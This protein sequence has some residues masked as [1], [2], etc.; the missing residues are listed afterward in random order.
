MTPLTDKW[1]EEHCLVLDNRISRD[2][3]AAWVAIQADARH[4]RAEAKRLGGMV[5]GEQA[6]RKAFV[7]PFFDR[8]LKAEAEVERL[9][10]RLSWALGMI[11]RL[12]LQGGDGDVFA[13]PPTEGR[14]VE[15][16]GLRAEIEEARAALALEPE[17]RP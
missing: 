16:V 17:R 1:F 14:L 4:H 13:V 7:T 5:R 12:T 3:S 6:Y 2:I 10:E 9:R 11:D 8:A 15:I